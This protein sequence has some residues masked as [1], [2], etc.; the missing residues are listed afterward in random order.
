MSSPS[1][2]VPPH[3]RDTTDVMLDR[4]IVRPEDKLARYMFYTGRI[5]I[6]VVVTCVLL[7]LRIAWSDF[8]GPWRSMESTQ[9]LVL[10]VFL[11]FVAAMFLYCQYVCSV[12]GPGYV[13]MDWVHWTTTLFYC[14]VFFKS[15]FPI[16]SY[17]RI[18]CKGISQL[19][20][21]YQFNRIR[22]WTKDNSARSSILVNGAISIG[23]SALTTASTA[24]GKTSQIY[25]F[26]EIIPILYLLTTRLQFFQMCAVDGPSLC[27]PQPAIE[28]D[29]LIFF[30]K[31]VRG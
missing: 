17:D 27:V 28:Y 8:F 22:I 1:T 10:V 25:F 19:I 6:F 14:F 13:P 4:I 2:Y 21:I 16:S 29:P 5:A 7:G 18:Y 30:I 15:V 23:P 31:K 12:R 9:G 20:L 26:F 11:H 3:L 24:K